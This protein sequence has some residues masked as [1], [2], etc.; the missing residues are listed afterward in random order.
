MRTIKLCKTLCLQDKKLRFVL[1]HIFVYKLIIIMEGIFIEIV[2]A[3]FLSHLIFNLVVGFSMWLL[4]MIAIMVD[5]ADGIYTA[6]CLKKRI[7][8]KK[9]RVTFEK[10]FEYWRFM[11]VGLLADVVL[12]ILPWYNRPYASIVLALIL[13]GV[14]LMSLM[15]H[16]KA[17]KS[18]VVKGQAVLEKIIECS[19][20][21]KAKELM[22]F[23]KQNSDNIKE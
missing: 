22:E 16:A 21:E 10:V 18:K 2:D 1:I 19:T 11:V 13:I 8:S 9:M 4:V 7:H 3:E 6:K 5:L 12:V 14:E 20:S 23:I 17:R 15:E